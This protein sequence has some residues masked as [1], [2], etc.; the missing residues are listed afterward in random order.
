MAMY[1][2]FVKVHK[3]I[4]RLEILSHDALR[5]DSIYFNVIIYSYVSDKSVIYWLDLSVILVQKLTVAGG[6]GTKNFRL[7]IKLEEYYSFW[8]SLH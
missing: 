8:K 1:S 6:G 2:V 3:K 5:F 7:F 4:S